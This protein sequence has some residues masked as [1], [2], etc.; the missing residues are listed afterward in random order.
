MHTQELLMVDVIVVRSDTFCYT[1]DFHNTCMPL[2]P[3]ASVFSPSTASPSCGSSL[4][5][6]ARSP[7]R[8]RPP[9]PLRPP[10]PRPLPPLSLPGTSMPL[11]LQNSKHCQWCC[12]M[13][14]QAMYTALKHISKISQDAASEGRLYLLYCFTSRS[15]RSSRTMILRPA[16]SVPLKVFTAVTAY[17]SKVCYNSQ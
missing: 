9:R 13:H 16:R 7:P 5:G 1:Y 17:S 2:L 8:P 6:A 3:S 10:L 12:L 4:R 11:S 15:S 14:H